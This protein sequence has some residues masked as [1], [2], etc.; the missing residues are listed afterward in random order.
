MSRDSRFAA[1]LGSL[2]GR[3]NPFS[4]PGQAT[5]LRPFTDA[6]EAVGYGTRCLVEFARSR[7]ICPELVLEW[8]GRGGI[9]RFQ[10]PDR[11]ECSEPQ[12]PVWRFERCP[13]P[14]ARAVRGQPCA[15]WK[16]IQ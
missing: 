11:F 6:G 1:F 8:W 5:L 10:P 13:H 7:G 16:R 9:Q 2:D 12:R 4:L 14:A 15:I 3:S